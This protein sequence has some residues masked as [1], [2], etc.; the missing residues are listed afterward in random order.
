M[1]VD[2]SFLRPLYTHDGP[3][4]TVV[5]DTDRTVEDAQQAIALRWR[6]LREDLVA[7]GA[8]DATLAALDDVVGM[9]SELAGE[10]GQIAIAAAGSVVLDERAQ[11]HPVTS[12]ARWERLP[13]VL[14][15]LTAMPDQ[16]TCLV[17][18]IDSVG[19]DIE[20]RGPA[21]LDEE[22]VAGVDHPVNKVRHGGLSNRRIQQR[23][24]N[25]VQHNAKLVAERVDE[26][27]RKTG[28]DLVVVAGESKVRKEFADELSG[29][30]RDLVAE[31]DTSGRPIDGQ[32]VSAQVAG[33]VRQHSEDTVAEALGRY[34]EE[35]GRGA[36]GVAGLDATVERLRR[37]QVDTVLVEPHGPAA[38]DMQLWAGT[39]PLAVARQ[40]EVLEAWGAQ[41]KYLVPA[42][43]ALIRAATSS[44]AGLVLAEAGAAGHQDGVGAL[45]RYAHEPARLHE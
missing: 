4:A 41:A 25:T 3:F 7:A 18:R 34:R 15:L 38:S 24:E 1:P 44:D 26:L 22:E 2:L 33:V 40:P 19:A 5:L 27:A 37:A 11:T 17:V 28:V 29:G 23:A 10:R 21:R 30:T 12:V 43:A 31:L 42:S 6:G 45:L 16:T 20:L 8:D 32:D 39:D 13:Y 9:P 36:L 14:P 35:V